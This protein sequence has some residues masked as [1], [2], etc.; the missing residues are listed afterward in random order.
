MKFGIWKRINK[1]KWFQRKSKQKSLNMIKKITYK[2]FEEK[3]PVK[4]I[5]SLQ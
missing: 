3:K 1:P 5:D 2:N 4:S